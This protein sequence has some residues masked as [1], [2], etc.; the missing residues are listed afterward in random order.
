MKNG[1]SEFCRIYSS[2]TEDNLRA[3]REIAEEIR[4]SDS[5]SIDQFKNMLDRSSQNLMDK[6]N[7]GRKSLRT[8]IAFEILPEYP[9]DVLKASLIIDAIINLLDDNL[10]EL[11]TKEER[12]L[13]VIELVRIMAIFNH[14][15]ITSA[16]RQKIFEY[17]NKILCIATSEIIYKE[18]IR[19]SGDFN[20]QLHNSIQ[21][22]NCKCLVTDIFFE[23]P[24]LELYGDDKRIRDIVSLTRIHR[25][26]FQIKKDYKDI[27]RDIENQT[28]T[29]I[30][31]L[32]KKH[33]SI[34]PY[35]DTMI[36]HY[37][38]KSGKIE[39]EEF[40]GDFQLI[41]R[42]LLELIQNE[43]AEY[44]RELKEIALDKN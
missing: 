26:L 35:I 10:D 2:T 14:L 27:E 11:M 22:Y 7:S 21:C 1:I 16:A 34:E 40:D 20:Q 36:N 5:I 39:P 32:S 37:E 43:I 25:A 6:W 38:Q 9:S 44:R 19:A 24:L 4:I 17:F 41:A 12:A 29:P 18:K 13:Y 42:N 8:E 28:E 33:S 31:I 3:I 30:V 23:L 15:S